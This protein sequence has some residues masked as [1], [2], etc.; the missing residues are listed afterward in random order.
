[1]SRVECKQLARTSLSF[2]LSIAMVLTSVPAQA[3]GETTGSGEGSVPSDATAASQ[4]IVSPE[5]EATLSSVDAQIDNDGLFESYVAQLIDDSLPEG[6]EPLFEV[7][8]ASSGTARLR[9]PA[10]S[11]SGNDLAVY[12]YLEG[13][14]AEVAAGNLTST[15]FEVPVE[16]FYDGPTT[17]TSEDLGCEIVVGGEINPEA[18]DAIRELLY[19]DIQ[20][21]VSVLLAEHPYEMYW[22]EAGTSFSSSPAGSFDVTGYDGEYE[23]TLAD[24][25][26]VKVWL[27]VSQDYREAG[28]EVS[29]PPGTFF[30]SVTTDPSK[31]TRVE[32]AIGRAATVALDN[33]GASALDQLTAFKEY[34]CSEVA[35]DDEA[36]DDANDT[37]YGDPWQLINV[38]DEDPDTNVV[39]EGYSKA[40]KYLVDLAE[41]PDVSCSLVS[42]TMGSDSGGATGEGAHMW[43]IVNMDD[44]ENYLVDVTNCDGTDEY[45]CSIGW[46]DLLFLVPN[47]DGDA[48]GYTFDVNGTNIYYSYDDE[49]IDLYTEEE[50]M[51]ATS[52]Y[53]GPGGEEPGADSKVFVDDQGVEHECYRIDTTVNG[54][55]GYVRILYWGG[56]YVDYA[57]GALAYYDGETDYYYYDPS[58]GVRFSVD[59]SDDENNPIESVSYVCDGVEHELG[60]LD[61]ERFYDDEP[62][63]EIPAGLEGPITITLTLG[64]GGHP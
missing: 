40:F 55:D 7:E 27:P 12:E 45:E 8:A 63:Y 4:V 3:F 5:P 62:I 60:A 18:G 64:E 1:M 6:S 53:E 57:N 36:A 42:G 25:D 13:Q 34:I 15:Y 21:V 17:W 31:I 49:T 19:V 44:G 28:S 10:R 52:Q 20:K 29:I 11:L 50:R 2:L 47:A 30:Y 56:Q 41:I 46:P 26:C 9:T 54:G 61:V 22:F 43:N 59:S 48:S 38:F 33:A 51:L 32:E 39:C 35:Y 58:T 24:N 37:P 14:I 16:V 23:A